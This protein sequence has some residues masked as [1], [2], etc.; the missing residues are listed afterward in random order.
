LS[1]GDRATEISL[2]EMLGPNHELYGQALIKTK[3]VA[4][5]CEAGRIREVA[6]HQLGRVARYEPDQ[7][8]HSHRNKQECRDRTGDST[9]DEPYH[10]PSFGLDASD[11]VAITLPMCRS[12][13]SSW[14]RVE[15]EPS[16]TAID[17]PW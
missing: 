2:Q 11:G 14:K 6:E 12:R 3:A 9:K 10:H 8:E 17:F 5:V 15:F 4:Q 1:R 7:D 16:L 13:M